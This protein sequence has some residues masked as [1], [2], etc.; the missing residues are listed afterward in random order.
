MKG[1]LPLL[2]ALFAGQF[3]GS[4]LAQRTNDPR[5]VSGP[6][7]PRNWETETEKRNRPE[8][9]VA[10]PAWPKNENLIEFSVDNNT[11]FRFYIDAASVSVEPDRV[12][13][14]T[15]IA[16]SGSGFVNMSYEG[17]RCESGTYKVYAY[18]RDGRWAARESEWRDID[19]RS[20]ARWHFELRAGYF[21]LGRT[22]TV[23]SAKDAVDALRRGYKPGVPGRDRLNY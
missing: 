12:V 5:E 6:E 16:R 11:A 3:F 7:V 15:L 19:S 14:Y 2:L 8:S 10:L 20:I 23:L 18:G 21:C 9:A 1:W 13:R 22:G 4:A 17:M